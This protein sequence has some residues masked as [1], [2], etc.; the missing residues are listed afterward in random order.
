[1]FRFSLT[2]RR[3]LPFAVAASLSLPVVACGHK[4]EVEL[5]PE[6]LMQK[7][8]SQPG[9]KTL[10]DGL[11]YKVLESGPP[12]GPQPH[13]GDT[14]MLIYEGRLPDGSIFDA[15]D[16]HGHGAYMQ[17]PL[18]GLVQGWMEGVPMMHV[19]DT[20]MLYVPAKLG[21]GD[22]EMGIIPSNSPLIFKIQLLG[23]TRGD[24]GQ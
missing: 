14:M 16:Q 19:G 9:V 15:S 17:M 20:W 12:N 11:A 8:M 1:M 10:P 5:T 13:K 3:F 6:Q 23:V 21:Y 7:E 24:N 22:R 4:E 18:D 2:P